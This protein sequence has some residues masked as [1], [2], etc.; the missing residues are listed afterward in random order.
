MIP[1]P[2]CRC[3]RE[4]TEGWRI[5]PVRCVQVRSASGRLR[6]L[7]E[8]EAFD[9]DLP[10]D[11][12]QHSSFRP[13]NEWQL[14]LDHPRDRASA[15][16]GRFPPFVSGAAPA[17]SD[18]ILFHKEAVCGQIVLSCP[19]SVNGPKTSAQINSRST[20]EKQ[21]RVFA[22]EPVRSAIRKK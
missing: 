19:C 16:K 2:V 11:R 15:A 14:S 13:L 8:L 20:R 21:F 5:A 17:S 6:S 4:F 3:A 1:S 12:L 9:S 7:Q 18:G 10:S 22:F